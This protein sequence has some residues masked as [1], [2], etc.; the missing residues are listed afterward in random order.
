MSFDAVSGLGGSSLAPLDRASA[1]TQVAAAT[2]TPAATPAPA[3]AP[4]EPPT[5]PPSPAKPG[6][7][8]LLVPTEPLSPTVLAELV[9][10]RL[11]LTGPAAGD[12]GQ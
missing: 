12:P 7:P 1:V 9:G 10:R 5:P 11:S 6:Q 8:V 4:G 2:Q 3:A